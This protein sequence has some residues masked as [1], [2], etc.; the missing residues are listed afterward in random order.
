[1][2]FSLIRIRLQIC[3]L[4]AACP[5]LMGFVL[6]SH[7]KATLPVST[8]SPSLTFVW[9]G[10][11][12]DISGK[13]EYKDGVH[14]DLDDQAFMRQL[15]TDALD[16]W[17]NVPGSYLKLQ[18][19][20]SENEAK[21]DKEDGLFS[22]VTDS[23]SNATTAAYANPDTKPETPTVISDCDISISDRQTKAKDLAFTIAHELGHCLGL[24]HSH[25]NYNA[26]MSYSRDV[27]SLSLGADDKAG[28]IYLYPDPAFVTSKPNE[29]ACGVL[30]KGLS[31][32]DKALFLIFFPCLT[33][34]AAVVARRSLGPILSL[35]RT[36]RTKS[37]EESSGTLR[38]PSQRTG[39]T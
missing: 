19:N 18:A 13:D 17:N 26:M 29:I 12:P 32:S 28:I 14:A 24:G 38:H 20:L 22:I 9:D 5:W 35:A 21:L 16:I 11:Y 15:L 8:G 4:L 2:N 6:L 39:E 36:P 33:L 7:N 23:S 25:T 27:R 31:G 30:G 37:A 3:G 34:V 10:N 1:M